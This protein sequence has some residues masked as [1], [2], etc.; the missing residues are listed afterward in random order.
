MKNKI[1]KTV[2]KYNLIS[3]GDKI[4]IALSGGADSVMLSEYL[5]SVK[6]ELDLTLEAAH[7]EH[8]IRGKESVRDMNF[9]I[10]YC[11]KNNIPLHIL[12]INAVDEAKA[13]GLS[14]EEYSRN[15]RY[16]YFKTLS[17]D[18]LATAHNATDNAETLLFR[19]ARGSSLNGLCAIPPKRDNIIR[20]L[21]E[22]NSDEIRKYLE[23][24]G[25][26]YCI[27]STNA[28]TDYTRNYI[29]SEILPRMQKLNPD[30]ISA[31]S[32]LTELV[33]AD[34]EYLESIASA[35]YEKACSDNQLR[36][37]R[38]K[39]LPD[40]I[41]GRVLAKY[42]KENSLPYDY[43]KIGNLKSLLAAP[44][45]FQ[46]DNDFTAVSNKST[47]RIAELSNCKTHYAAEISKLSFDDYLKIC[48]NGSKAF[49][50]C[51]DYDKIIGSVTVRTRQEGDKLSPEGRHCTKTLKKLFNEL[52]V[53]I[54]I[55]N[56]IPVVADDAGV[57]GIC[58]YC[59]DE[60]VK[61]GSETKAVLTVNIHT[62]EKI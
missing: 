60:R 47:L 34:E 36:I 40:A 37:D 33:A 54:E 50:F 56:S 19:I 61:L 62:E 59:T 15:R 29:R 41:L 39:T 42:L 21:I 52:A 17:C 20:P 48:K 4:L 7:I 18:K 2:D 28:S 6:N 49:D 9:C 58:G 57:I 13:A 26:A 22:V 30:F 44:S 55:R 38:L 32:R 11:R 12:R 8:G 23:E 35:E 51:C 3:K 27:D 46:I 14:V 25:I 16:E 24:N 45:R 43:Y 5:L 1:S 10:D 53:P 31:S